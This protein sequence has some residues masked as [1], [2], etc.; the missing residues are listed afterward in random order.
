[1][2]L[3]RSFETARVA[4]YHHQWTLPHL[5]NPLPRLSLDN[6]GVEGPLERHI[7]HMSPPSP[8]TEPSR[9][10]SGKTSGVAPRRGG[11]A[12]FISTTLM[13]LVRA[14]DNWLRLRRRKS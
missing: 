11:M 13:R 12:A 2:C 5:R 3:P 1:M 9:R 4:S 6:K 8:R 7:W 10:P 14:L